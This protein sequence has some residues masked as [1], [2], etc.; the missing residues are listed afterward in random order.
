MRRCPDITVSSCR[1]VVTV[2]LLLNDGNARVQTRGHW[3]AG[4]GD[5][6]RYPGIKAA[7]FHIPGLC[8]F[9][10]GY[11]FIYGGGIHKRNCNV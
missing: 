7:D 8:R 2:V 1:S 3:G 11:L 6:R 10:C 5:W 9:I 4:G